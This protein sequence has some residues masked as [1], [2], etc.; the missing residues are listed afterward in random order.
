MHSH[1]FALIWDYITQTDKKIVVYSIV[2][3]RNDIYL[4]PGWSA[5]SIL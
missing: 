3:E 4:I 1:S 2:K 5:E